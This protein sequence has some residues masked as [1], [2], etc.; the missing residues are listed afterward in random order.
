MVKPKPKLA[1]GG[2][3]KV[4]AAAETAPDVVH[5]DDEEEYEG[6]EMEEGVEGEEEGE[7]AEGEG[8]SSSKLVNHQLSA[9]PSFFIV[10][11]L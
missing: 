10:P 2:R 11:F 5:S 3:K 7:E 9:L 1:S 8:K 6:G 4:P